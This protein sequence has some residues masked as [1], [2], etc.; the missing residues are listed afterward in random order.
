MFYSQL[1][2]VMAG[3]APVDSVSQ[4]TLSFQIYRKACDILGA[5]RCHRA[6]MCDELPPAIGDLVRAEVIRLYDIR[7]KAWRRPPPKVQVEKPVHREGFEDW[8]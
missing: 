5:L 1:E 8:I 3:E 2:K 4:T 7:R 6:Q